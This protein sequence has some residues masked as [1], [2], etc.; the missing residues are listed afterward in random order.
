MASSGSTSYSIRGHSVVFHEESHEYFVDGVKVP[1]VTEILGR[2]SRLHGLDDYADI[3]QDVLRMAAARGTALHKEIEEYEKQGVRGFSEEFGNYLPLK[4]RHGV[5][6]VASELPVLIFD[7]SGKPVCAGRLDLL[8]TINGDAALGD[9]KRTSRLY[10]KKVSLQLNLYRI[11]CIQSYGKA[12]DRLFVMRL[13]KNV[14]EF[15]EFPVDE[16]AARDVLRTAGAVISGSSRVPEK[17]GAARVPQQAAA[18][19]QAPAASRDVNAAARTDVNPAKPRSKYYSDRP[20]SFWSPACWFTLKGRLSSFHFWIMLMIWSFALC[21]FSALFSRDGGSDERALFIFVSLSVFFPVFLSICVRRSHDYDVD[22]LEDWFRIMFTVYQFC[23]VFFLISSFGRFLV[24]D[25]MDKL[26]HMSFH[27]ELNF[28]EKAGVMGL[29][30]VVVT[31]VPL[32][33]IQF[34][35]LIGKGGTSGDKGE[36]EYGPDPLEKRS[37]ERSV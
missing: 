18:R 1:S 2:Y 14:S 17:A 4:I 7:D 26:Q 5:K 10:P 9:I 30:A 27:G 25:M 29:V 13:R 12:C 37:D 36:N 35:F 31:A 33:A 6:V 23:A 21:R 24:M 15:R 16:N 8:A 28:V 32:M 22:V 20:F 19:Q 3:P 11:G 34:M